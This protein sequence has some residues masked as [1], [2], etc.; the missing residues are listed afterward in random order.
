MPV[1]L[2]WSFRLAMILPYPLLEQIVLSP[3]HSSPASKNASSRLSMT[4]TN[5][6]VFLPRM[7]KIIFAQYTKRSPN[8]F[9]CFSVLNIRN[10]Y[11]RNLSLSSLRIGSGQALPSLFGLQIHLRECST[12][13]QGMAE[14]PSIQ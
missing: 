14:L 10:V 8:L 1:F 5:S 7:S 11:G 2:L 3:R 12:R 9:W 4:A 13:V 6:I